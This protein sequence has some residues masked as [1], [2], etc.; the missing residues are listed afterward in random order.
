MAGKYSQ[1]C[2]L[3]CKQLHPLR[4][5]CELQSEILSVIIVF[6]QAHQFAALNYQTRCLLHYL[7][8][9]LVPFPHKSN[10]RS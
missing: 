7:R 2:R 10:G 4:P 5:Q 1:F 3:G 6:Y 9:L 8:I